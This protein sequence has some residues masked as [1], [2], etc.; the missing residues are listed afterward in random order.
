M[1]PVYHRGKNNSPLHVA[2]FPPYLPCIEV[3]VRLKKKLF[4][5]TEDVYTRTVRKVKK[6]RF[7]FFFLKT[8]CIFLCTYDIVF[9][10]N[11]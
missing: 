9:L 11:A 7:S 2:S 6:D 4:I 5:H 3:N 10:C 1:Q 8:N